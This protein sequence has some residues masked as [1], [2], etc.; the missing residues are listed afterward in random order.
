MDKTT[1][2]RRLQI[3]PESCLQWRLLKRA[4]HLRCNPFPRSCSLT[5][6]DR[7]GKRREALLIPWYQ[8]TCFPSSRVTCAISS[9]T[10]VTDRR[11]SSSSSQKAT[12]PDGVLMGGFLLMVSTR[13]AHGSMPRK[14][15]GFTN[16]MAPT[17]L[18]I[19]YIIWINISC[20]EWMNEQILILRFAHTH[21]FNHY[22]LSGPS[23][24]ARCI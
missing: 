3:P 13:Q 10:F 24:N 19:M 2:R 17:G 5:H 4:V 12:G 18:A 15:Y 9:L 6:E 23:W 21:R 8:P 7:Q 1:A 20:H 11:A 22:W 16:Q 14:K